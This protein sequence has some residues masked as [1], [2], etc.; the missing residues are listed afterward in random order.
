MT[1]FEIRFLGLPKGALLTHGTVRKPERSVP[2]RDAKTRN[3]TITDHRDLRN[4][5]KFA[6]ARAPLV[7]RPVMLAC[8]LL[9]AR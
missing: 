1:V 8:N 3:A 4:V 5:I 6:H 2:F 9:V 7:L